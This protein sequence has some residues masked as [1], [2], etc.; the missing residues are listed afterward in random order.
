MV[1]KMNY[2]QTMEWLFT[3]LPM[4]QRLGQVAYKADLENITK[5][6]AHLDNPQNQLKSI[7][8]AGTNGKGSTCHMLASVLQEAGYKV[9]LHTSPHLKHFGERSRIN[10]QNMSEDYIIK[11]VQKH[12]EFIEQNSF[13]FFE[14]AV[15]IGFDYFAENQVDIAIIETGLGGRLDS[16]NIIQPEI[17]VITNIGL[18]HTAILGDTL[19]EIA[20]EKA[21]IIKHKTP[22][23]IGET[24]PETKS[25]FQQKAKEMQSEIYFAPVIEHESVIE[26]VEMAKS[27]QKS[28]I[29][30]AEMTKSKNSELLKTDLKGNYQ[31]KNL[32]TAYLTLNVLQQKG[33]K[34]SDEN[35]QSGLKNVVKNTGLR[36]RWDILQDKPLV[37]ADTAHNPDGIQHIIQQIKAT[38]HKK[39]HLVLGFVNDKDVKSILNLFPKDAQYYFCQ[40][41]VPRKFPIEDLQKIVPKNLNAQYFKT[42]DVALQAAKNNANDDDMIYVGGST[43]VV[44]E[45]V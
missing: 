7:H 40:P 31:L 45:V 11:F 44:A 30:P 26:L 4:F 1:I 18:D 12:K 17:S 16:T 37:V 25:V 5:F 21:G 33:W 42:V 39:L 35:I 15:A 36:G 9:G 3:Q 20:A 6:C 34:I 2:T 10:G 38:P 43:F 22:V 8:V 29:E 19:A 41:D 24:V 32:Q 28:V 23:V 13:S 27:N 14:V